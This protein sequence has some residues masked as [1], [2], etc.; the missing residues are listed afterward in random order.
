MLAPTMND[1]ECRIILGL[2]GAPKRKATSVL[3]ASA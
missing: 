1:W 2:Q 3:G